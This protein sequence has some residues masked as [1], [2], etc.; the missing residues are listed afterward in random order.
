[1]E[2]KFAIIFALIELPIQWRR[3]TIGEAIKTPSAGR[4]WYNLVENQIRL[5]WVNGA[6]FET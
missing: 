1:M 5:P 6:R 2:S 3:Q 4:K